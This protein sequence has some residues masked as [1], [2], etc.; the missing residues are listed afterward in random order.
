MSAVLQV[1]IFV[2]QSRGRGFLA[3]VP[4]VISCV[5]LVAILAVPTSLT[6]CIHGKQEYIIL[7]V[8]PGQFLK[9]ANETVIA[10]SAAVCD[11]MKSV[12][13]LCPLQRRRAVPLPRVSGARLRRTPSRPL[14][15]GERGATQRAAAPRERGG[16]SQ[17]LPQVPDQPLGLPGTRAAE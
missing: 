15:P 4:R 2:L 13:V 6:A 9:A 12:C 5:T 16:S 10:A 17:V 3:T 11:K 8:Y 1:C 7:Q 14:Q